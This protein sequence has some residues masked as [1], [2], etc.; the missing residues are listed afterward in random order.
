MAFLFKGNLSGYLCDDCIEAIPNLTIRLYRPVD[1]PLNLAAAAVAAT[2]ETFRA[3]TPADVDA[4]A[5][6]LIAEGTADELGNFEFSIGGDYGGSAFEVDFVCGTVPRK[7]PIPKRDFDVRQFHLT[8][9]LPQWKQIQG[10][11]PTSTEAGKEDLVFSWKYALASKW[12]CF[13]KGFYFDAWT[14]CGRLLDCKTQKPLEGVKIIAMDADFISDDTIGSGLTDATGH[15]RIDYSS[16]DFKKTFLSPWIN[17]ETD[18]TFPW[19]SGPDVYFHAEYQGLSL[20]LETAANCRKNVGYC[21][22]VDLCL[23]GVVVDVPKIPADFTHIGVTGKHDIQADI[24]PVT[25]KTVKSGYNHAFFGTL[26]L[27]GTLTKTLNGQPMEYKFQF[28]EVA[29]PATA[30]T[31]GAW[32]DVTP[33]MIEESNIGYL[34]LSISPSVKTECY[35]NRNPTTTGADVTL[36][37]NWIQVPQAANFVPNQNGEI[38]R[39]NSEK[40]TG[41]TNIDM[42]G[43]AVANIGLPTIPG[44]PHIGNRYFAL[45]MLQREVGSVAAGALAGISRPLA[46]FNTRYL[47]VPTHGSWAPAR[48]TDWAAVSLD[49][50]EVVSGSSGCNKITNA[51]HIK[52]NARHENLASVSLSIIGP[53]KPG[54]TFGFSPIVAAPPEN[55]QNSVTLN[56]SPVND[57]NELLPCAY[58]IQL[59]ATLNLTTGDTGLGAIQDLVSFCKV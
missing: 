27:V 11:E 12:W 4:K 32:Q 22:C 35:V 53:A 19:A 14:I 36:N 38:L 1:N 34:L 48:R 31:A 28:Q 37:G 5:K 17:V 29:T 59:S 23:D 26:P 21:L 54:Q 49:V 50:Q 46:L 41:I 39:L 18:P 25:G 56:I 30:P 7:P 15:F 24:S 40:M 13:I 44:I 8:T 52:Y 6:R 55:A 33:A 10:N 57:V 58:T 9:V 45:R 42:A 47:N 2:K 51:L 43:Q 20:A 3:L 16:V